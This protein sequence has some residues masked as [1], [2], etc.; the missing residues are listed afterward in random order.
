MSQFDRRHFLIA[1]LGSAAG[2]SLSSSLAVAADSKS[3]EKKQALVLPSASIPGEPTSLFLTWWTDPTTTMVIQWIGLAEQK[4]VIHYGLHKSSDS[5]VAR[6]LTKPF[7]DTTLKVHR[8]E[9]TGL[10]PDTDYQFRIDDSKRNYRF[11]TMPAKATN[12]IQFVSGGDCGTGS[13]ALETNLLAARQ[14]PQFAFIG[15]DLAYDNGKSPKT[16]LTFLENYSKTMRD[17][18]GR[19]IPMVTCIGNHEVTTSGILGT[20]L[21]ATR[22]PIAPHYLSVFDGIFHDST[23]GVLDFGDYLSLVMLDT[24]HIA[25]VK[26]AQTSWLED[27]LKSRQSLPHLLAANHVP[28]YPSHRSFENTGKE[29]RK[30]WCPLFEKYNVDAVLEHHDHTFKRTHPLKDGLYD[31]HGVLYLG[32]GSWGKL[33]PVTRSE[34]RPYLANFGESYHISVHRLEGNQRYHLALTSSGRIADICQTN[35]KRIARRG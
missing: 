35:G 21:L 15:G 29:N 12:T 2:W 30:Y 13:A 23:Y 19:V 8:C 5:L 11:R 27:A 31:K 24:G 1:S 26:G 17:S 22:K 33:R 10:K 16:F 7:P 14:D 25:P 32:D 3:S 20:N 28:A 18:Q 34:E 4:S 9:L 6:V